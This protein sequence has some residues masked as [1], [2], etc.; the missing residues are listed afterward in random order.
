MGS[1]PVL[2][3][4]RRVG[5]CGCYR[6]HC[7]RTIINRL[8]RAL[9]AGRQNDYGKR[10]FVL[11]CLPCF[12]ELLDLTSGRAWLALLPHHVRGHAAVFQRAQ[13]HRTPKIHLVGKKIGS[14]CEPARYSGAARKLQW[15]R[16]SEPGPS[17]DK[18]GACELAKC[19]RYSRRHTPT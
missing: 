11:D 3:M 12:G 16:R 19:R 2:R 17:L 9:V 1:R 7:S 5:R 8:G 4:K 10:N 15:F 18:Q 14:A 13:V 6:A